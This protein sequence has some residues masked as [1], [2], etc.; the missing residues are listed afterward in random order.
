EA[1]IEVDGTRTILAA[2][3]AQGVRRL[4]VVTSIGVGDSQDQVPLPFK[5]LMKTVLRKVMQA[6]E[7]QEKLVMASGLDWTIV[8]PGGL[9][10]GPPTDRYTAGL[11]KSITA[12]QVSRA[13]VAA[14]VLQQLAD[15]TYV[16]KTPAIT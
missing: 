10:D 3:Q 6:K 8:R 12:G 14:F 9:T 1:P 13:D 7:E 4:I 15:A 11:D 5:M 2:M 16:Q